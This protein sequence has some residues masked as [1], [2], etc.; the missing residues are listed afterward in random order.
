[1]AEYEKKLRKIYGFKVVSK[2]KKV[3]SSSTTITTTTTTKP[4]KI[5]I[6][7]NPENITRLF[8]KNLNI[9]EVDQPQLC[10]LIDGITH[11]EWIMDKKSQRWYGS[12]FVEVST[13]ENAGKAVGTLHNQKIYGRVIHCAFSKP[14]TKSIWPP[15]NSRI[16]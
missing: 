9:K 7:P 1:M 13:P 6:V 4:I 5:K 12:V 16:V 3:S 8:V 11:I 2:K 14:D 15:P 10:D